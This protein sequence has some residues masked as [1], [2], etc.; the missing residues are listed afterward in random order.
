MSEE[1]NK[2]LWC[3]KLLHFLQGL[4]GKNILLFLKWKAKVKAL[5]FRGK[6]TFNFH[7]LQLRKESPWAVVGQGSVDS[8]QAG[9]GSSA[10]SHPAKQ[11]QPRGAAGAAPAPQAVSLQAV[12]SSVHLIK[13]SHSSSEV[14]ICVSAL[15]L[16]KAEAASLVAF[17]YRKEKKTATPLQHRHDSK[18]WSF[19]DT[20]FSHHE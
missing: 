11:S 4:L 3:W 1:K 10:H 13:C 6:G 9:M 18:C 2:F 15:L 5:L 7:C 12:A 17:C 8:G 14:L 16:R 20:G 19:Q